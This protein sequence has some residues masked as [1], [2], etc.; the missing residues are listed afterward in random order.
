MAT[1]SD[2]ERT[3]LAEVST[4]ATVRNTILAKARVKLTADTDNQVEV[5]DLRE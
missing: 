3:Q 4:T 2:V 1:I 5:V